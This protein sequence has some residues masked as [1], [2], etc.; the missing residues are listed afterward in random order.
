M[1]F[2]YQP[3]D[4]SEP[5]FDETARLLGEY[6]DIVGIFFD[7]AVPWPEAAA[8]QPYHPDQEA[9]IN[10]RLA[11]AKPHH[12]VLLATSL[13][14]SDRVSLSR[15]LGATELPR[16]G[17]WQDRNFNSPE[18]I[19]AYLNWCK[20]LIDRFA[21]DYFVYVM[22]VNAAFDDV[23]DPRF[24][25][26]HDAI[27][28]IYPALKAWYPDLPLIIEFMLMNDEGMAA[29][30]DV[31][32]ALLP[33]TDIFGVS[34][35]PFL[36]AGG[37]PAQI[38]EDW[39]SRGKAL[40]GDKPFAILETNH[41]AEDFL[42][43]T[44]GVAMPGREGSVLIPG[45]PRWQADYLRRLFSEAQALNAAFVIQWTSRDLDL[46]ADRLRGTGTAFDPDLQPMANLAKDS[47]LFDEAG[48][49]RPALAVWEDWFL[50]PVV[51]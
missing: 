41:L 3:Y 33:Y 19:S 44:L 49:P 36:H 31:T 39:F 21:P 17:V 51:D 50:R 48:R 2:A 16:P 8:Q 7:G 5:A 12:D 23:N 47:G 28:Q 34:T 43:P 42:H 10:R 46:L 40:A 11:I 37:D 38:Q 29:R 30:Q 45:E 20:D 18:V 27:A 4:W 32:S 25:A 14:G 24:I 26:L 15:Y 13:L 1:G 22:E 9:D 6:G 35:Y